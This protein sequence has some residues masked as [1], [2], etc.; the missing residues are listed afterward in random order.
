MGLMVGQTVTPDH[1]SD[2]ADSLGVVKAT[3]W[4]EEYKM[5][6]LLVPAGF[7]GL[8]KIDAKANPRIA[9]GILMDPPS[10]H[11]QSVSIRLKWDKSHPS[12]S[13]EEF[14]SKL[15]TFDKEGQLIRKICTDIESY[16]HASLV[17]HGADPFAQKVGDDGKIVNPGYSSKQ[18]YSDNRGDTIEYYCMDWKSQEGNGVEIL[19]NT[20][21]YNLNKQKQNNTETN[22]DMKL[23]DLIGAGLLNLE[24]GVE[25]T[26]E[27]VMAALRKT[28]ADLKD[29]G[30]SS[31]NKDTEITQ[32]K[33]QLT[34][35]QGKAKTTEDSKFIDMGK[36]HLD[37][38][39]EAVKANY[40]KLHGSGADE[41]ILTLLDSCSLEQLNSLGKQYNEQLEQ[42]YPLSCS[43]CGSKEV[44]R[45][46]SVNVP[47]E[48]DDFSNSGKGVKDNDTIIEEIRKQKLK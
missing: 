9:R 16:Y 33:E 25:V 14:W 42:K 10:V 17:S 31:G 27:N 24:E 36:T 20:M 44:N 46:S 2:I 43:K 3:F 30:I 29:L 39:R 45:A 11:S 28:V 7:N 8:F 5:G 26:E 6:K 18:D 41:T 1:N 34:E 21:V 19:N 37:T 15:G 22:V 40:K 13:D 23:E 32:L 35:A 12:L 4:Q 38:T 48:D 47:E